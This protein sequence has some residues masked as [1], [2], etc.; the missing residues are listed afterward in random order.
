M[1]E[2]IK[3]IIQTK[4]MLARITS[5]LNLTFIKKILGI[6]SNLRNTNPQVYDYINLVNLVVFKQ[7][8]IN[9]QNSSNI[10]ESTNLTNYINQ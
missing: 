7:K 5:N 4:K 2:A 3:L 10:I 1:E 6:W 8:I 9:S